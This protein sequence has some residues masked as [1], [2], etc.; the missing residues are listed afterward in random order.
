LVQADNL[1][2]STYSFRYPLVQKYWQIS[3]GL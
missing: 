1:S 2:G 3:R